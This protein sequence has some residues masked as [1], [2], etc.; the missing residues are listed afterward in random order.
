MQHL[1]GELE[2]KAERDLDGNAGE[3]DNAAFDM[4]A[5]L[6]SNQAKN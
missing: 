6:P 3:N 1:Q 4:V 2:D 5:M